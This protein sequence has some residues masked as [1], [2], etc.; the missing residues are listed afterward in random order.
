METAMADNLIENFI[1]NQS[2][3][4]TVLKKTLDAQ[5]MRQRAHAQNIANAETPG[6]RRM[7]VS[8]E[9]D[10][11][12]VLQGEA[13]AMLRS[14][15]R[16]LGLDGNGGLE[17]LAPKALREKPSAD[18][19]G[20]NGVNIDLEMA[21]MAETQIRYLASLEFLKRRYSGLKTAIRG[22]GQ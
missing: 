7:A 15:S 19:P 10:L 17:D 22:S 3:G 16:H 14:D 21:E 20:T 11:K 6:Y 9:S 1:L 4:T 12:E 18:G 5:S 8:F 13:G 2:P